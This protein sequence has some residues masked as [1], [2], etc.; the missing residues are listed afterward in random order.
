M[1]TGGRDGHDGRDRNRGCR[2][3]DGMLEPEDVAESVVVGLASESVLALPHPRVATSLR[4]KV[5][6][7]DRWLE[8]MRRLQDRFPKGI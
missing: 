4:R 1:P 3:V 2:R 8:G 5:D 7:Y 6:D